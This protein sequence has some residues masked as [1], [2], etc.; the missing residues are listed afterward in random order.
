MEGSLAMMWNNISLSEHEATTTT[1]EP[2]ILSSPKNA[3][4]V[5]LAMRK[6]VS[7]FDIDRNLKSQWKITDEMET[8][9]IGEN[10]YLFIF[11]TA[12]TYDSIF[13]R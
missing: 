5:R 12:N 6:H 4:V 2:H 7:L 10:L 13:E 9:A 3:L 1:I 11:S 8:T